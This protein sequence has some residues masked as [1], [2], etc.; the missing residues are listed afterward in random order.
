VSRAAFRKGIPSLF[1]S[2]KTMFSECD[3]E[4]IMRDLVEHMVESLKHSSRLPGS[5]VEEE[6]SCRFWAEYYL[7]QHYDFIE[8]YDQALALVNGMIERSPASTELLMTKA[9]ILKH[10]G[11]FEQAKDVM[12][13]ARK[14][15]LADRFINSKATKYL[16]RYGDTEKAESTI[17]M[18]VRQDVSFKLQELMDMQCIWYIYETARA[19]HR[20]NS[21]GL[22]LKYYRQVEK[23]FND[24]Y[25]DQ[26]DFHL[27]SLR[28]CTLRSYIKMIEWADK[29]FTRREFVDALLGAIEC[30]LQLFDEMPSDKKVALASDA[31]DSA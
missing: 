1:N 20:K 10:V 30:Y 25:D 19:H 21:L 24:F 29:V 22:A 13:E 23:V 6:L 7:V 15:D 3:K 18:F 8:E 11:D 5:D 27:Y 28:K 17:K 12:D 16:L 4:R 26:L 31:N 9:R 14:L 2:F